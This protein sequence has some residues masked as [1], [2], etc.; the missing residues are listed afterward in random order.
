MKKINLF[1]QIPCL[2]EAT[3]LPLVIAS[4]PHEIP[5]VAAINT[6][7]IDDGSTDN[8]VETAEAIGVDYIVQNDRVLGLAKSFCH[9]IEVALH[10]GADIIVNLD[11][12]NQYKGSDIPKLIQPLLDKKA[13]I[14]VGARN[15]MGH[16]EFSFIKKILQTFGSKIISELANVNIPDT[17]SGFRAFTASAARTISI[18]SSFS[19]TLEMLCQASRLGLKVASVPIDVNKKTRESRLFRTPIGFI[20]QQLKTLLLVFLIHYPLRVFGWFAIISLFLTLLT[21]PLSV[22]SPFSSMQVPLDLVFFYGILMT[23]IFLVAALF[24]AVLQ[25]LYYT[26]MDMRS[27]LRSLQ[28]NTAATFLEFTLKSPVAPGRWKAFNIDEHNLRITD[29]K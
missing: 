20:Y 2:N 24:G 25:V 17:T 11:G 12:D 14:V 4:L 21:K 6:I 3:T 5:G 22:T 18:M 9:G 28:A 8:T 1:I 15:I 26:M 16:K 10:L 19:Y 23:S 13:D 7:V 27:R 29:K